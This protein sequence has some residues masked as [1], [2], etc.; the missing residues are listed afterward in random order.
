MSFDQLGLAPPLLRT[1]T[2]AGYTTPTPIQAQ[3]IPHVLAGRD[4]L[5]CAQTGTGKTA[6]FALPILH[7]L[8][9]AG[10]PAARERPP[11]PRAGAIADA[12]TGVANPRKLSDLREP[13]GAAVLGHL[14]RRRPAAPGASPAQRRR[15]RRRDARPAAGSD[16]PG[17][18][19]SGG[20][21]DFRARRSRPHARHGLSCPT[22]VASIAKLPVK[23]QTVFFSATMPGP[24]EQLANAILRDP[25]QVRVAPD[26]ATT[27]LIEQ[28]VCFVPQRAQAAVADQ[29]AAKGPGDAGARL[30]AHQARRRSR[31]AAIDAVGHQGRRR[32]TATRAK[33]RAN[34]AWNASSQTGRRCW[35]RP[36][37][38]PAG[39]TW[40]TSRTSS[41]S[42]CRTRPKRTSIA[43]AVR[44][45]QA[46][47][48][49]RCRSAI[50]ESVSTCEA[51]SGS[52]ADRLSSTPIMRRARLKPWPARLLARRGRATT[53][54]N[55]RVQD[56]V[57]GIAGL[58]IRL[59]APRQAKGRADQHRAVRGRA[60]VAV[61]DEPPPPRE[62]RAGHGA[63]TGSASK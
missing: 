49:S 25:V 23:R 15:R 3:A 62:G 7:R 29:H 8:T 9:H 34:A 18:C 12:R 38:L 21:R 22:C 40:I 30:H 19:R 46:P 43:S 51:S 33:R 27:E 50:P 42:I 35:W 26:K 52:F 5:G 24:I 48:E 36:I 14:R 4:V 39:S 60:K 32:S 59:V 6:A 56:A 44:A 41:I 47:R 57:R 53:E 37:W 45:A 54:R 16:E 28:S 13:H 63:A 55:S 61:V 31:R 11:H 10:N 1:V 20:R 2:A 58:I 17:T